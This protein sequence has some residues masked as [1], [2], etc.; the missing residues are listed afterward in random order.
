MEEYDTFYYPT[1]TEKLRMAKQSTEQRV[2]ILLRTLKPGQQIIITR[3]GTE[4]D[5]EFSVEFK[6]PC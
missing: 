4:E 3:C 1:P 2:H 5:C 6:Q